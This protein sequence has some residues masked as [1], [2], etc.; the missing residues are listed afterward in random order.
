MIIDLVEVLAE[1]SAVQVRQATII[2]EDGT[3]ISRTYQRWTL[4]RGD[5]LAGQDPLVIKICQAIWT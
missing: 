4:T 2:E 5:D 3:E 1:T